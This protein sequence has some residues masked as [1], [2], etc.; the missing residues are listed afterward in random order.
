MATYN[1]E[2]KIRIVQLN[3]VGK[4]PADL[5]REFYIKDG[6]GVVVTYHFNVEKCKFFPTREGYYKM[7]SKT[8]SRQRF[9][10]ANIYKEREKFQNLY[11]FKLVYK[12]R[13]NIEVKNS[14]LKNRHDFS[15]TIYVGIFAI[16][17]QILQRNSQ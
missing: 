15:Q 14:E 12:D 5:S 4:S 13:Y 10:F 2:F 9:R 3:K 7:G 16:N 11:I 6:E 17:I 8:E 1:E